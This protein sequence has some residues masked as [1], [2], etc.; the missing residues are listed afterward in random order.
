MLLTRYIWSLS[1]L[2]GALGM[3]I[4]A[5]AQWTIPEHSWI[6]DFTTEIGIAAASGGIVGFIYEHLIRRD[7]LEQVRH[8]LQDIVDAD[9]R[10]LG[11]TAIYD[12]RTDKQ[13][14]VTLRGLIQS[15]ERELVF[16][17][18]GLGPI[19]NEHGDDLD[20][21]MARGCRVKFLIFDLH[22]GPAAVLEASLGKGDLIDNLRGS[23][24]SA[25]AMDRKCK[26]PGCFE[27]RLFDV[28]P[29]FGAIAIDRTEANGRIY[30]ELNCFR[31]PGDQC[32][33]F[34]LAKLPSGLFHNYNRQITDLW[35][36]A[37]PAQSADAPKSAESATA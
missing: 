25:L 29:T 28:V 34:E 21:I 17:G 26:T 22:A 4:I 11:I 15:A 20:R 33:G 16:L 10:R 14:R 36:A 18:I 12:S 8:Q 27:L 6:K 37:R 1:A 9:S 23:F 7:L 32:P 30:V 24:G 2:L 19:I 13:R 5:I 3:I 35:Q 31:S